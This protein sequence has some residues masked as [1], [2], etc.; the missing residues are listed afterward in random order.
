MF[1][2]KKSPAQVAF[3]ESAKFRKKY[4]LSVFKNREVRVM[5]IIFHDYIHALTGL[6]TTD[7]EEAI[8]ERIQLLLLQGN[9]PEESEE[10][11][12]Y[13][14]GALYDAVSPLIVGI[15]SSREYFPDAICP[16]AM[17][18]WHSQVNK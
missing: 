6:G 9:Y 17:A 10:C 3:I 8:V 4:N 16:D 11:F 18:Y 2:K 15:A 13:F 5:E 7:K 12:P 1:F 14:N